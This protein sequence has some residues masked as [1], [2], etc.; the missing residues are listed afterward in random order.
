MSKIERL[1]KTTLIA[2]LLIM[3]SI[4]VY[5]DVSVTSWTFFQ[6]VYQDPG[7]DLYHGDIVIQGNPNNMKATVKGDLGLVNSDLTGIRG[8]AGTSQINGNKLFS[9]IALRAL[10]PDD[11]FLLRNLT[12]LNFSKVANTLNDV[13]SK[14]YNRGSALYIDTDKTNESHITIN[15]QSF[16]DLTSSQLNNQFLNNSVIVNNVSAQAAGGAI[17]ASAGIEETVASDVESSI[18]LLFEKLHDVSADRSYI[19]FSKNSTY[20]SYAYSQAQGGALYASGLVNT[21]LGDGI[22]TIRVDFSTVSSNGEGGNS[23]QSHKIDFNYAQVVGQNSQAQGGAFFIAGSVGIQSQELISNG[24]A[25]LNFFNSIMLF[26]SNSVRASGINSQAQGGGLFVAGG[27]GN[28]VNNFNAGSAEVLFLASQIAFAKNYIQGSNTVQAHGAGAFFSGLSILRSSAKGAEGAID[29]GFDGSKIEFTANTIAVNS[30]SQ[31]LGAGLFIAAAVSGANGLVQDPSAISLIA[32]L[33]FNQNSLSALNN[34]ISAGQ[35]SQALG[36]GSFISGAVAFG[37][38]SKINYQAE[39]VQTNID[40]LT[41]R[42]AFDKNTISASNNSQISGAGLFIGGIVASENSLIAGNISDKKG[43]IVSFV[44]STMSISANTLNSYG[45]NQAFGAGLSIAG[46]V[47]GG[48]NALANNGEVIIAFRD[49]SLS[50]NDNNINSGSAYSQVLGGGI[51]IIGAIAGGIGNGDGSP[52]SANNGKVDV[53]FSTA[54]IILQGNNSARGIGVSAY[55]QSLGGGL[56]IAGAVAGGN[57]TQAKSGEAN[58]EFSSSI[59]LISQNSASQGGGIFIGGAVV[60]GVNTLVENGKVAVSFTSSVINIENNKAQEG[61]GLYAAISA[62]GGSGSSVR[63]AGLVNINFIGSTVTFKGNTAS[64]GRGAAI[65]AANGT[66]ITFEDGRVEFIGNGIANVG[67]GVIYLDSNAVVDFYSAD[68]LEIIAKNNKALYGGFL[69]ISGRNIDFEGVVDISSNSAYQGGGLYLSNS[70]VTFKNKV[71]ITNNNAQF[72]AALYLAGSSQIKFEK[73]TVISFNNASQGAILQWQSQIIPNLTLLDNFTVEGNYARQSG[74]FVNLS[75]QS[76]TIEIRESDDKAI[77]FIGNKAM[78]YGGVIYALNSTVTLRNAGGADNVLT[79]KDNKD[80]LFS[81]RPNTNDIYLLGSTLNIEGFAGGNASFLSGIYARNSIVNW[82][83]TI[84]LDGYNYFDNTLIS[85]KPFTIGRVDPTKVST[86]V[87]TNNEALVLNSNNGITI[88]NTRLEFR[89]NRN[90]ALNVLAGAGLQILDDLSSLVFLNNTNLTGAGV[91][92]IKA[93]DEIVVYVSNIIAKNN[94]ALK[95]G[96]L[97]LD[98]VGSPSLIEFHLGTNVTENIEI[99]NNV[100]RSSGG[101]IS[102]ISGALDVEPLHLYIQSKNISFLNNK[103]TTRGGAIYINGAHSIVSLSGNNAIFSQNY[104]SSARL[105]DPRA[106][107]NDIYLSNGGTLNINTKNVKILSGIYIE[108]GEVDGSSPTATINLEKIEFIG[109]YNHFQSAIF[110]KIVGNLVFSN[111][112]LLYKYSVGFNL[113]NRLADEKTFFNFTNTNAKFINNNGTVITAMSGDDNSAGISFNASNVTFQDN[114]FATDL[115]GSLATNKIFSSATF[116]NSTVYFQNNK[117]TNSIDTARGAAISAADSSSIS[118]ANSNVYFQNNS[119]LGSGTD[120]D[121]SGGAA[122]YVRNTE[123]DEISYVPRVFFDNSNVVFS[124]NETNSYGGAIFSGN[125][126]DALNFVE[127]DDLWVGFMD[128]KVSFTNNSALSG[129]AIAA[130]RQTKMAFVNTPVSFIGNT[131]SRD[132]GAIAVSADKQLNFN[133]KPVTKLTFD[134]SPAVFNANTADNG[135]A[136]VVR[137]YNA[138]DSLLDLTAEIIF[139]RT[140]VDFVN[141][142]AISTGGAIYV[143]G[144][145]SDEFVGARFI[146]GI[147]VTFSNNKALNGSGGAVALQT[148]AALVF[149]NATGLFINNTASLYGGA[150]YGVYILK[151]AGATDSNTNIDFQNSNIVFRG[152]RAKEGAAIY[153]RGDESGAGWYAGINFDGGSVLIENNISQE[154][155]SGTIA[156]ANEFST[157]SFINKTNVT[158][159]NNYADY[160]SFLYLQGANIS[161]DYLIFDGD[162][163]ISNNKAKKG[164]AFY[165]ANGAKIA[166]AGNV[167]INNNISTDLEADTNNLGGGAIFMDDRTPGDYTDADFSNAQSLQVIGNSAGGSGGFIYLSAKDDIS[168]QDYSWTLN[169]NANISNNKALKGAGG[170]IYARSIFIDVTQPGLKLNA[171]NGQIT[172]SGNVATSSGGAIFLLGSHMLLNA[173]NADIIFTNNTAFNGT[174]SKI[175]N[176]IF[177]AFDTPSAAQKA[178]L[179]LSAANGKTI[180][181]DSGLIGE[182]GT[183]INAG[184]SGDTGKTIIAGNVNFAGTV[185][186]LEGGRI[187]F[188]GYTG[189]KYGQY[190]NSSMY[191]SSIAANAKGVFAIGSPTSTKSIKAI[192]DNAEF[193]QNATFETVINA[194]NR[195]YG[196]IVISSF[197]TASADTK[198]RLNVN[199]NGVVKGRAIVFDPNAKQTATWYV[200][201]GFGS[202]DTTNIDAFTKILAMERPS[203]TGSQYTGGFYIIRHQDFDDLSNLSANQSNIGKSISTSKWTTDGQSLELVKSIRL[204]IGD[205]GQ[206]YGREILDSLSGVFLTNALKLS[207]LNNN[208]STLYSRMDTEIVRNYV[209]AKDEERIFDSV[210]TQLNLAGVVYEQ[211]TDNPRSFK[212][213]GYALQAGINLVQSQ[214][215]LGGFVVDFDINNIKQGEDKANLTQVGAG[216]FGGWYGQKTNTKASLLFSQQNFDTRRNIYIQS[217]SEGNE[218]KR[219]ATADFDSYSI[220]LGAQTEYVID[221]G[222]ETDIKPF[223]GLQNTMVFTDEITEKGADPVNL[224]V[225]ENNY[226]RSVANIGIG[227]GDSGGKFK[228]NAKFY[229]GYIIIGNSTEYEISFISDSLN[230]SRRN[231]KSFDEGRLYAGLGIGADFEL[232]K[233][234]SVFANADITNGGQSYGYN[235]NLGLNVKIG[236]TKGSKVRIRADKVSTTEREFIISVLNDKKQRYIAEQKKL[237]KQI[238]DEDARVALEIVVGKPV[239]L[240]NLGGEIIY[241][242]DKSVAKDY[243]KSIKD[244]P[245]VTDKSEIKIKTVKLDDLIVYAGLYKDISTD[246]RNLALLQSQQEQASQKTKNQIVAVD[247]STSSTQAEVVAVNAL[248]EKV[249]EINRNSVISEVVKDY[250]QSSQINVDVV[251]GKIVLTSR[252]VATLGIRA[253]ENVY[254]V[255]YADR[256]FIFGNNNKAAEFVSKLR[257]AGAVLSTRAIRAVPIGKDLTIPVSE[258]NG[259][260]D[261]ASKMIIVSYTSDNSEIMTPD[262]KK[263]RE[264]ENVVN[265][266][267]MKQAQERRDKH[268]MSFRLEVP[269]YVS[270]AARLTSGEKEQVRK[271]SLEI[272]KSKYSKITIEG[273]TDN[274]APE[275]SNIQLSK[276]RVEEVYKEFILNG[277]PSNRIEYIGF[278]SSLPLA[279]NTTPENRYKNRRVDIFVE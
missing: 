178:I 262:E 14:N 227:L 6:Q 239:Y 51:S 17:F 139:S 60:G 16:S 213:N 250:E 43:A 114:T 58:V 263:R 258:I 85:N 142:T 182:K 28:A 106:R 130:A 149:E 200:S 204:A 94:Y 95:G 186:V 7:S 97:A 260:T 78:G 144:G 109:G 267:L 216:I 222:Y 235:A 184:S 80:S 39:V 3:S 174:Y 123:Y 88:E 246:R 188:A 210:W 140:K 55:S 66:N 89:N 91:L 64:S 136:I 223:I 24:N 273:H 102:V 127:S 21:A 209:I 1:L 40:S 32:N 65:Y 137:S 253:G 237:G 63:N 108:S 171:S 68:N 42:F 37:A 50:I 8:S 177:L 2:A 119:A 271:Y 150:I 207:A 166:F 242:D 54:N 219:T 27:V 96:F 154:G 34:T 195:S 274:A 220:N 36:A 62:I 118:F 232:N 203:V 161:S 156:L 189:N 38:G 101:A 221:A 19:G 84:R 181:L 141:N 180:R 87:W 234:V 179:D 249:N 215:F 255:R 107:S 257:A 173:D 230:K 236:T 248:P 112:T 164:S 266:K 277:I 67:N 76:L 125:Y 231:I 41:S 202:F 81:L 151:A 77:N 23:L 25:E 252:A 74:G 185:N 268:A 206:V 52:Y 79:F 145:E 279:P 82:D 49:T 120:I 143:L 110:Q 5:A 191:I 57:R 192:V 259:N 105:A 11:D 169:G 157:I 69:Y 147:N 217:A 194:S 33:T 20:A 165:L 190:A 131:A 167:I 99:T 247:R 205:K 270:Y 214:N 35:N 226:F 261:K 238:T 122:I 132:G 4:C 134:N 59:I 197:V 152:N 56:F 22:K 233:D 138:S 211:N 47:D 15:F 86:F 148:K 225:E 176:D 160:G 241:F 229:A 18:S 9:G 243:E 265:V 73:E 159:R 13:I 269:R 100:S 208:A 175:G 53:L 126:S 196:Q 111:T 124:G 92:S 133:E 228:W 71:S 93:E 75:R 61:G 201:E 198:F 72:G 116:I 155:S 275:P 46:A 45:S 129:G 224:R 251:D 44:G 48:V 172:F 212:S 256:D 26:D 128:S 121:E 218:Y 146:N 103:A 199:G 12:L 276:Q 170:A 240:I 10:Q 135:G 162:I 244:L 163:N 83:N 168:A 31:G 245:T 98:G 193:S 153:L 90:G 183:V 187:Y 254:I 278:G 272:N 264:S 115:S 70:I 29:L 117:N 104:Q 30:N 113:P 158:V